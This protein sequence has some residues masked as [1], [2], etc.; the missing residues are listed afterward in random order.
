[1]LITSRSSCSILHSTH[2]AR[3]ELVSHIRNTHVQ[4]QLRK[5]TTAEDKG[6]NCS[7]TS[8]FSTILP[9]T[10][11]ATQMV[12]ILAADQVKEGARAQME[13]RV[14]SPRNKSNRGWLTEHWYWSQAI[15]K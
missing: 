7:Q 2:V 11:K 6:R 3:N 14:V 9:L 4:E 10:W 12:Y 5:D 1:M 8:S 13:S 15:T